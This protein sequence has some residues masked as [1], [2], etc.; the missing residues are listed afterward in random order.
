MPRGK[1]S[2]LNKDIVAGILLIL[3]SLWVIAEAQEFRAA[4]ERFRG[5]SPALFPTLLSICIILLAL[6]MIIRGLRK[7]Y[8]WDFALDLRKKY[9]YLTLGLVVATIV[10][11]LTMEFLGFFLVTFLYSLL[12][13]IWMRGA[14][15]FRAAIIAFAATGL[16]YLV[17][18]KL[19]LVPF[20]GGEIFE[21]L[22]M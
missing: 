10:Y 18:H 9:F 16:I 15:P 8:H 12:L 5:I 21:M 1:K 11:G 7:G 2:F 6:L 14:P 22:R 13:I 19:M 4:A 3:F 20:P 17:F